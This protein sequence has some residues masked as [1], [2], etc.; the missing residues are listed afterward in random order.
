[1]PDSL[2]RVLSARPHGRLHHLALTAV[3]VAVTACGG[4]S[5]TPTGP[6]PAGLS[7]SRAFSGTGRPLT[8]GDHFSVAVDGVPFSAFTLTAVCSMPGPEIVTLVAV[9][10][11][12]TSSTSL[13]ITALAQPGIHTIAAAQFTQSTMTVI[14]GASSSGFMAFQTLGSGSI[15]ITSLSATRVDG[16]VDLV[17]VPTSGATASRVVT[18]SFSAA[19]VAPGCMSPGGTFAGGP[20]P[21]A[22]EGGIGGVPTGSFTA[23]IDGIGFNGAYG[24]MAT[25]TNG[26]L[27]ISGSDDRH[28]LQLGVIGV[29]G[30]GTFAIDPLTPATAAL[31]QNGTANAW[32]A[33][34]G[35]GSGVITVISLTPTEVTGTFTV[36][37]VPA[38]GAAALGPRTITS[39]LFSVPLG[40]SIPVPP[41]VPTDPAPP[42]GTP[43]GL[44]MLI[45]GMEFH[46]A[47]GAHATR[48]AQGFVTIA[49]V[50][51]QARAFGMAIL[52]SAV[53]TY[54]FNPVGH[55][56]IYSSSGQQWFTSRPGGG[57]SVTIT[58]ISTT[59]ITGSFTA[60]LA[61]GAT[62]TNQ[63][64]LE[65][66]GTFNLPF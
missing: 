25:L 44:T 60:T 17:L 41:S 31:A 49:G 21:G 16:I 33:G 6:S 23:L 51:L 55:N 1:M 61:P 46:P 62:N 43:A 29:Q 66:T 58:S 38:V 9:S 2:R 22:G 11:L 36:T 45:D 12:G 54:S 50:D 8:L 39:G 24:L 42:I 4:T 28:T 32:F 7:A 64:T 57:G 63:R 20:V 47:G 65:A 35:T 3:I 30:P 15:T 40:A 37:L 10:G 5:P 14:S 27:S 53:G 48:T 19:I 18:G 52:A 59:G 13:A 26:Q 56:A 34:A